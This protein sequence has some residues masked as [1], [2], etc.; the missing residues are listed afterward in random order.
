[1]HHYTRVLRLFLTC[2]ICLISFPLFSGPSRNILIIHSYHRGFLW[3]D[4]IDS[5]IQRAFRA[6]G[7]NH[8]LYSEY[9]DVKRFSPEAREEPFRRYLAEKFG[10]AEF[11]AVI[12]S[13]DS[14]FRFAVE[15][16]DSLFPGVPIVFCGL[17]NYD[18]YPGE[19]IEGITGVAEDFDVGANLRL[20]ARLH[21]EGTLVAVVA[22]STTTGIL[23]LGQFALAAESVFAPSLQ[24]ELLAD[25]SEAELR[26]RLALLPKGTVIL[27]LGFWRDSDN[28]SFNHAESIV[29]LTATG[30]PVYTCWDHMI[31]YGTVGGIVIDGGIQGEQAAEYAL[32]ILDGTP[33]DQLPVRR[34]DLTRAIFDYPSLKEHRIRSGRLPRDRVIRNLPNKVYYRYPRLFALSLSI[35]TLLSVLVAL[36]VL[37]ILKRRQAEEL[38]RTL[39]ENA[40]DVILVHDQEGRILMINNAVEK[41]HGYSVAEARQMYIQ[42]LNTPEYS[43]SFPDRLREQLSRIKYDCEITHAAR[44]GRPLEFE[45]S[46]VRLSYRGRE[47]IMAILRDIG[48]RNRSRRELEKRALEKDL[49]IRE[50]HHRVKNNLQIIISL[51]RLQADSSGD[52]KSSQIL[53]DSQKRVNAMATVHE[54]LYQSDDLAHIDARGYLSGLAE[55]LSGSYASTIFTLDYAVKAEDIQLPIDQA[56]PL[57]I[58][59]TEM[60]T[61]SLKYGGSDG[62]CRFELVLKLL[63]GSIMLNYRDWGPGFDFAGRVR[64]TLGL[65]LVDSLSKQ[66]GG[67]LSHDGKND[68]SLTFPLA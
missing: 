51:L 43:E 26:H 52:A 62:T 30:F 15:N 32:R 33:A 6:T 38:F 35:L 36:L 19:R 5:G 55:Q 58:I 2:L 24:Y 61:N 60:I 8:E 29:L 9:Y 64:K 10:P 37:N 17:N 23:N 31:Q 45:S 46:A 22:D 14:A 49:L 48:E 27:N 13:D 21:G 68:F 20:I 39:F 40:P 1:M 25:L 11:D 67:E 42:E 34:E 12:V 56:I 18:I 53:M 54:M 57:G 50:I 66:L 44:D 7:G 65:E 63:D 28:I 3:T 47:V 4:T 16:R 59:V 41:V